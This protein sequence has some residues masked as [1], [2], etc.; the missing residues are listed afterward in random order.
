[1]NR[2]L[3]RS[4]VVLLLVLFS[5]GVAG[6]AEEAGDRS[7]RKF[8]EAV[9]LLETWIQAVIDFDRLPGLTIAVVH[10]QDLVFA[11]GFGHADVERSV[12]A[13][14]S[15]IYGICSISKVFTA[16]GL[17]QLRDAG[18][19]GL[20]DQVS[21]YLPWFAPEMVNGDA[22]PPTLRDLLRHS[23]GLPC[24]PD[25][26]IWPN[27]EKL[28]P[29]REELIQRVSKLKMSYPTNTRF[30]YSNLGYSLLG[31]VISTV[32]GVAYEEYIQKNIID[33]LG[34][35]ATTPHMPERGTGKEIA[36]GYGR[37]PR[38]G[39]RVRL[40]DRDPRA[41]A[42]SWAFASTVED[43]AK[44]ARWQFRV[45]NGEEDGVLS[46][47]TLREMHTLQWSDSDWGLGFSIWQ[48]GDEKFV[49]HQGGCSGY[50][51]Q[52]ILN[53][54]DKI[55]VV[56]MVN[57]KDAPQFTLVFRAY[58]I[59]APALIEAANDEE[60]QSAWERY[61]GYYT[62]DESWSEAEVL[63]WEDSLAL[64][65]VPTP[66]PLGSLVRLK[67]VQGDVFRQVNDNGELGKHYVF[68]A[69]SAGNIV[70]MRFNNNQLKKTAR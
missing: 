44:F 41:L 34:M 17:M 29:S 59:M 28:C 51:S 70:S 31:E 50:K 26:T 36:V 53:P 10:D 56:V 45:L 61:T 11:R 4:V 16:I 54:E 49:G 2:S 21:T 52:F 6:R 20:D 32:S 38:M 3:H 66:N 42:P 27:P 9:T 65:W 39:V 30:N 33:P 68:K 46:P 43:M 7:S 15:T 69:D 5:P 35:R 48:M 24:E 8:R 67:R 60:G 14:A 58:E 22:R 55:A 63:E 62:A 1:M 37:W 57:A 40:P 23:S 19:L 47:P 64:M 12:E 25:R 18:Q 13:R